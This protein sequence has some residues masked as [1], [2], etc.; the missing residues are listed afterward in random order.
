[1]KRGEKRSAES[2]RKSVETRRRNAKPAKLGPDNSAYRG[3]RNVSPDGYVRLLTGRLRYR[4]EHRLVMERHLGR[5]LRSEE[6][7][8][9]INGDKADNRIENLEV[10]TRAQHMREHLS[11]GDIPKITV[12]C[13]LSDRD[14]LEIRRDNRPQAQIAR[15]YGVHQVTISKVKRG[16]LRAGV[17]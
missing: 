4:L 6:I 15:E 10:L 3:G 11:L 8:H 2:I 1:M 17:T 5:S 12:P 13:R 7:V 14:V 16:V 9:H